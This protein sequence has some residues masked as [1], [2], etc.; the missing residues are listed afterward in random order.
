MVATNTAHSTSLNKSQPGKPSVPT[1]S[2]AG[3]LRRRSRPPVRHHRT[4]H[5]PAA[6]RRNQRHASCCYHAVVEERV[7]FGIENRAKV[8][9]IFCGK[10]LLA[11]IRPATSSCGIALG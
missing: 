4:N 7:E 1:G 3:P 10:P 6:R 5:V 9:T 11:V 2:A 8:D